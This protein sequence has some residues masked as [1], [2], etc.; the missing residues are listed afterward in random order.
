MNGSGPLRSGPTG[1]VSGFSV[2]PFVATKIKEIWPA[3]IRNDRLVMMYKILHKLFPESLWNK[4]QQRSEP[5]TYRP[6]NISYLH[7]PRLNLESSNSGFHYSGM[8]NWND[9]PISY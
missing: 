1:P 2:M 5:F 4:Y 9:I 3:L 6:R 7:I 8:R